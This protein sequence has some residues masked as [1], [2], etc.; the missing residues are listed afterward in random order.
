MLKEQNMTAAE[1]LSKGFLPK[2]LV[3][4]GYT[5]A[6]LLEAGLDEQ[7]IA[8]ATMPANQP[9]GSNIGVA[10]AVPLV[11]LAVM[12]SRRCF[13][14][15]GSSLIALME[16]MPGPLPQSRQGVSILTF[17]GHMGCAGLR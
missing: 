12:C 4:V 8:A 11:L 13:S 5:E 15:R 9:G 6:E 14:F 10:V 7:T 3:V 17:H 16:P 2:T 1:L